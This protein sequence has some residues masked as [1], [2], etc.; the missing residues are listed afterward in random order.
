MR[1]TLLISTV[2]VVAAIPSAAARAVDRPDAWVT[3]S[4]KI[5]LLSADRVHGMDVNVDT[6]DGRV[7]LHGVVGSQ[8]EKDL[9][10]QLA[11]KVD[12]VR[13][14]R[15]LLQ[16]ASGSRRDVMKR[17]DDQLEKDV[18]AALDR[19]LQ[20]ADSPI[21]VESVHD[22]V[23][24]LSG[25]AA[26]ISDHLRALTVASQVN[27]VRRVETQIA[28]PSELAD[29][30]LWDEGKSGATVQGGGVEDAWITTRVKLRFMT[31]AEVPAS[32]INVDTRD[33]TVTLFG[34]VAAEAQKQ[35]A[36]DVANQADG[37][38]RLDNKLQVVPLADRDAVAVQDADLRQE[39]MQ[40]LH[41]RPDLES[42]DIRVEVED[43]VI[44]L[45]GTVDSQTERFTALTAARITRGARA[46]VDDL[47][48]RYRDTR[49]G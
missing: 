6:I 10:E 12:G 46:V 5:A 38:A 22:G 39:V 14:T 29:V 41:A 2:L 42:G 16:V 45:S 48:V 40:R 33:G 49:R 47:K 36:T 21:E 44:R 25:K 19:T 17:A 34:I 27:G 37:V 15:N 18:R 13:K 4:V 26:T 23:V 8:R 28:S 9:A 11:R 35:A 43:G 31:D 20:L 30:E 32:D 1:P 7:T 3:A 24:L